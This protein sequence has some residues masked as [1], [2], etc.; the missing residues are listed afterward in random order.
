MTSTPVRKPDPPCA[1]TPAILLGTGI[2]LFDQL[3][4]HWVVAKLP[5]DCYPAVIVPRFCLLLHIRNP[6]GA[7]GILADYPHLLSLLSIAVILFLIL[8][9]DHLAE[10]RPE[11]GLALASVLGGI[12]GNLLD[13][14][15][16]EGGVVDFIQFYC[17]PLPLTNAINL[18]DAAIT[19]GVVVFI[20]SSLLHAHDDAGATSTDS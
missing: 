8:R 4:K 5:V 14:L 18:A 17:G 9:F 7:W 19:V 11:Q 12:A 15:F 16:R 1:R 20:V 2:V 3:L 13:R 6:G 10:R